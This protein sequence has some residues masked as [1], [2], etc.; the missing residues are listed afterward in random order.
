MKAISPSPFCLTS[1]RED[2]FKQFQR[3]MDDQLRE[4]ASKEAEEAEEDAEYRAER[5]AF[6]QR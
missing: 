3:M 5:E 6:E 2:D 1:A 4:M